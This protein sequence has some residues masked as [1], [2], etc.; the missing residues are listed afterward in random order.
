MTKI[1][2]HLN[3]EFPVTVLT[4]GPIFS[5]L[6]PALTL[7]APANRLTEKQVSTPR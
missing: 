5:Y 2:F 4:K 7:D 3:F 6:F 1:T